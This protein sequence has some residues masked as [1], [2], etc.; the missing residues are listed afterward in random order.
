MA[1]KSEYP[2]VVREFQELGVK[3]QEVEDILRVGPKGAP[4]SQEIAF[5]YVRPE[6]VDGFSKWHTA[7][8]AEAKAAH[9]G[10]WLYGTDLQAR[11]KSRP[12]GEGKPVY[13]ITG[14]GGKKIDLRTIPTAQMISVL[15]AEIAK[16]TLFGKEL[17]GAWLHTR[18]HLIESKRA[19]EKDGKLVVGPEANKPFTG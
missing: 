16:L 8:G 19:T 9:F 10:T 7:S 5:R 12:V 18:N 6:T 4:G 14:K 17:A 15:N 2:K 3:M 1:S 13:E 11:Q